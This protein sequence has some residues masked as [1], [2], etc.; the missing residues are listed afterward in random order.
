MK[1]FIGCSSSDDIQEIYN[2]DCSNYLEELFK[3]DNELIFGAYNKGLMAISYNIAKKYNRKITGIT[4]K[5]F[6]ES[7][8][9]LKCDQEIITTNIS[10]RTDNLIEESDALIF[11]PG[12]IGTIYE[13]FSAIESKRSGEF[14]KPI[15]IYNSN[16]FFDKLLLFL[17]NIYNDNFTSKSVKDTYHISKSA[18]DTIEYLNKYFK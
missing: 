17:E 6:V 18:T 4:P 3:L 9:D 5:I 16:N 2:T 13:L 11:L 8:N 14:N 12:G 15:I 1:L 7:L 10:R